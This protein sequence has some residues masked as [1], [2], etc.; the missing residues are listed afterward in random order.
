MV[1][2]D[3]GFECVLRCLRVVIWAK[4]CDRCCCSA[5]GH[6]ALGGLVLN[7]RDWGLLWLFLVLNRARQGVGN[8]SDGR[9]TKDR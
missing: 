6:G 1:V 9:E 5:P 8:D 7:E 2:L 3:Y 4:E